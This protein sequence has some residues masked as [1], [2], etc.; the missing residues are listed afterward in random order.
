MTTDR[1]PDLSDLA[2]AHEAKFL[3]AALSVRKPVAPEACGHCLNCEAPLPAGQRWCDAACAR[4][5]EF[6]D[7]R[8]RAAQSDE[9]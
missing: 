2:T 1:I 4:E 8:E 5:W 9:G 6:Y 3:D 7:D